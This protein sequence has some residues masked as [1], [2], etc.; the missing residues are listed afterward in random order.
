MSLYSKKQFYVIRVSLFFATF[1]LVLVGILYFRY[2]R[3]NRISISA[4][5]KNVEN[6]LFNTKYLTYKQQLD[7]I[8]RKFTFEFIA[9]DGVSLY[10][11]V[12][13]VQW[14]SPVK[15]IK[16]FTTQHEYRTKYLPH[17]LWVY[18]KVSTSK[19]WVVTTIDSFPYDL[20]MQV[21]PKRNLK[22]IFTYDLLTKPVKLT[23]S[24]FSPIVIRFKVAFRKGDKF[25]YTDKEV[26]I[27]YKDLVKN[28]VANSKVKVKEYTATLADKG[29][30]DL[31]SRK[32]FNKS[33][34]SIGCPLFF[35]CVFRQSVEAIKLINT[36]KV[37]FKD[38]A[39]FYKN[40][41]LP[42]PVTIWV[43]ETKGGEIAYHKVVFSKE[44]LEKPVDQC[45]IFEGPVNSN[46]MNF[47]LYARLRIPVTYIKFEA[48]QVKNDVPRSVEIRK[49]SVGNKTN[50]LL[51]NIYLPKQ[52]Y[53]RFV[54]YFLDN[55][56]R[57]IDS[58]VHNV[59][60]KN[61][62]RHSSV[63]SKFKLLLGR[64]WGG[65]SV[66][67]ATSEDTVE[68]QNVFDPIVTPLDLFLLHVPVG[69]EYNA[70]LQVTDP[71]GDFLTYF[72]VDAP[73]WARITAKSDYE[74]RLII[75]VSG[76][77][78]KP[79]KYNFKIGIT[80]GTHTIYHSWMVLVDKNKY[81]LCLIQPEEANFG[82]WINHGSLVGLKWNPLNKCKDIKASVYLTTTNL[83]TSSKGAKYLGDIVIDLGQYTINTK[84]LASSK[85]YAWLVYKRDKQVIGFAQIGEF[86]LG[87]LNSV[88]SN[89]NP[90]VN[91]LL[92][93]PADKK[94]EFALNT[95]HFVLRLFA[96]KGANLET[97]G[98]KVYLD[99]KDITDLAIF[100]KPK[101]P[102]ITLLINL[103]HL[104]RGGHKL[105]IW[106]KDT[107]GRISKFVYKFAILSNSEKVA[108]PITI[109]KD[110][111]VIAGIVIPREQ[112]KIVIIGL[113]FFVLALT[114]PFFT[115]LIE[116]KSLV[117]TQIKVSNTDLAT[118]EQDERFG[119]TLKP[120]DE[121]V[122]D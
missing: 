32:F 27:Y 25:Y 80:D 88:D 23:A 33:E 13:R 14:T 37:V 20:L 1:I 51:D 109:L 54:I 57:V 15:N 38:E 79:G 9:G 60:S 77:P 94:Q 68:E 113:A 6:V 29:V 106:A 66:K 98:V 45:E 84:S 91:I 30:I 21:P 39:L 99:N 59:G 117:D 81:S 48:Q 55:Q 82:K 96:S 12:A 121:I 100:S 74:G 31:T 120:G 69:Q 85:Y 56:G 92:I 3:E 64:L 41:D 115:Y 70:S 43:Y 61:L 97:K 49:L 119:T 86:Y 10:G 42:T 62:S 47:I 5:D 36:G 103:E 63:F 52:K 28:S 50:F 95:V 102:I 101:A 4:T 58:C 111:V 118:F 16:F 34:L 19:K 93:S 73:I 110:E 72:V 26:R 76:K 2:L 17:D 44:A 105:E 46:T 53:D 8:T 89:P 40:I 22:L 35:Q 24:E 65:W 78:D 75:N 87:N 107:K 114:L 7:N 116:K 83:Y 122:L 104:T 11:V 18:P 67:A 108:A 112:V 71:D 90:F